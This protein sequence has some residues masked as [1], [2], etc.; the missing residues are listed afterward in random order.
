MAL[1]SKT[2]RYTYN[3]LNNRM[4]VRDLIEELQQHDLDRRVVVSLSYLNDLSRSRT[5]KRGEVINLSS[6]T[7]DRALLIIHATTD[8]PV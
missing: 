7:Y 4:T 8:N 3:L 6:E 2:C 1:T 5:L